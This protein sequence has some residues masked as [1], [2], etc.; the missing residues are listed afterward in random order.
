MTRQ[1]KFRMRNSMPYKFVMIYIGSSTRFDVS[2]QN[3]FAN[4]GYGVYMKSVAHNGPDFAT[5]K[6]VLE[7]VA[8]MQLKDITC[9][10]IFEYLPQSKVMAVP[11]GSMAFHRTGKSNVVVSI[12]WDNASDRLQD[13]REIANEIC[14][15]ILGDK[16][17]L[18]NPSSFGYGNY[19]ELPG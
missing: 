15:A 4:H 17:L 10:V 9:T 16:S 1:G 14:G 7:K 8:E 13:A 5:N 18:N 19:G 6:R 11:N 3:D 2:L 12:R